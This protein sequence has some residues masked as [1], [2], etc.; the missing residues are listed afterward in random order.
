MGSTLPATAHW[1]LRAILADHQAEPWLR[2]ELLA[3]LQPVIHLSPSYARAIR[4]M[5]DDAGEAAD[6]PDAP[7]ATL[8]SLT[9]GSVRLVAGD[10]M[11][12]L[13]QAIDALHEVDAFLGQLTD[14]LTGLL[15]AALDL[16]A[17]LGRADI[18]NDP[19]AIVRPSIRP[20]EQN[21]DHDHWARLVDWLW[22][23]WKHLDLT[24]PQASR[25]LVERWRHMPYLTFQRL[26]AAAVTDSDHFTLEEKLQVLIDA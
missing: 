14:E 6:E 11:P 8:E 17:V 19:G 9:E 3:L 20:H 15:R 5:M 10:R 26:R 18:D 12:T 4:A 13:A 24:A 1:D 22:R 23:G 16:F 25:A 2:Q 7:G 21:R